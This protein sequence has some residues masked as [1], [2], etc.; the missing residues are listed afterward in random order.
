MFGEEQC[1]SECVCEGVAGDPL[2]L[3]ELV[4]VVVVTSASH[5]STSQ[6]VLPTCNIFL[7][8]SDINKNINIKEPIASR[9]QKYCIK[10]IRL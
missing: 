6:P 9:T 4:V 1:E 8:N 5:I 2:V 7:L 3:V 10:H